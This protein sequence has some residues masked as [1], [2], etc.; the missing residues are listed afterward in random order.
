MLF[1]YVFKFITGDNEGE[2]VLCEEENLQA[3]L[4]TMYITYGF[5]RKELTYYGKI[6]VEEGKMLG[7]DTY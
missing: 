5:N 6:T 1:D 2:I 4:N 7:Y 3:A